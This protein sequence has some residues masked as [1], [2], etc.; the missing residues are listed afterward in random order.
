MRKIMILLAVTAVMVPA[1][2]ASNAQLSTARGVSIALENNA[3][4]QSYVSGES[5]TPEIFAEVLTFLDQLDPRESAVTKKIDQL[6]VLADEVGS[7]LTDVDPATREQL[8]PVMNS[9]FDKYGRRNRNEIILRL[10]NRF[11]FW[12]PDQLDSLA[13]MVRNDEVHSIS[14][15]LIWIL[16]HA[17]EAE[18]RNFLFNA[19]HNRNLRP[20]AWFPL[21]LAFKFGK[22]ND[23][24]GLKRALS[25]V[26]PEKIKPE[27]HPANLDGTALAT[28][29]DLYA[30]VKSKLQ[31]NV[32]QEFCT[33]ALVPLAGRAE[34]H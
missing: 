31:E 9:L 19:L 21:A 20:L 27:P 10:F 28:T 25:F 6:L 12:T 4:I 16:E 17:N 3:K 5:A 34:A 2:F 22:R 30:E 13:R 7:Q 18:R 23:I 11:W 24:A 14:T 33:R 32:Q 1:A 29:A 15:Q 26:N 8:Q